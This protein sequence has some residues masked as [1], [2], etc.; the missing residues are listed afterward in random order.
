M[1]G[2]FYFI[3]MGYIPTKRSFINGSSGFFENVEK[4]KD[5]IIL[6]ESV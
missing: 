3:L 6:L 5:L 1:F 2:D 4:I